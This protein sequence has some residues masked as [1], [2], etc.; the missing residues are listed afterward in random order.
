MTSPPDVQNVPDVWGLLEDVVLDGG[1]GALKNG[2][3]RRIIIALTQRDRFM[4]VP[5]KATGEQLIAIRKQFM[6]DLHAQM[7]PSA[8]NS[9]RVALAAAPKPEEKP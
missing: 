1:C 3:V 9:Y 6:I 5:K 2:T 7:G 8:E 4:L